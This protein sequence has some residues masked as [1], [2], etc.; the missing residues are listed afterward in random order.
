MIAGKMGS[1]TIQDGQLARA[2]AVCDDSAIS[3][4]GMTVEAL[5][6]LNR[7][8]DRRLRADC[9]ISIAWF[10]ALLRIGRNGGSMTMSELA[11][12]LALTNGGVT[13][14]IDKM[15]EAGFIR[16]EPCAT[17]RRV[18]YAVLTAAGVEKWAE[19]SEAHLA[20]L[21]REFTGRMSAAELD[22]VVTVMD[23]LRHDR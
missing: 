8:F 23:R 21:H 13:R 19:A 7:S 5:T 1:M 2:T 12:Q 11:G 16:R 22:T 17:D 4:Y 18:S 14:M 20:D 3:A 9:G 15:A 10:E 6:R